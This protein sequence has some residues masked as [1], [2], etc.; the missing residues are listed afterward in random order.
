VTDKATQKRRGFV[1]VEF[2]SDEAADK[3]TV[4][5]FHTIDEVQVYN[6]Y[7]QSCMIA[8]Y[9]KTLIG[10]IKYHAMQGSSLFTSYAEFLTSY[11]I[12]IDYYMC[13]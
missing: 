8:S 7:H 12:S 6:I 1:F 10:D 3:A 5:T 2:T 13:P 9:T 4:E 11:G